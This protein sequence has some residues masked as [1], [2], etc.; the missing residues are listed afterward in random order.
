LID[1]SFAVNDEQV[2]EVVVSAQRRLSV[3]SGGFMFKP[4][5]RSLFLGSGISPFLGGGDWCAFPVCGL[6]YSH[7]QFFLKF[8]HANLYI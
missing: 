7:G 8:L 2:D 6:G 5:T 4:Y 3:S 1:E